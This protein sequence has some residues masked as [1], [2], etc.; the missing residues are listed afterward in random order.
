MGWYVKGRLLFQ[1]DG[2]AGN[3]IGNGCSDTDI[4]VLGRR[5]TTSFREMIITARKRHTLSAWGTI[6]A[7]N[8][9]QVFPGQRSGP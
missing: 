7:P 5:A 3:S 8:L 6:A 2:L 1:L 9:Y 4:G